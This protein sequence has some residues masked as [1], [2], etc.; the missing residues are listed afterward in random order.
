MTT[1]D[2]GSTFQNRAAGP[3]ASPLP[4]MK[5]CGRKMAMGWPLKRPTP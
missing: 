4:F 2:E 5:V 3:T 1:T